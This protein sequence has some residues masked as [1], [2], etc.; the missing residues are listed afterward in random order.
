MVRVFNYLE[1]SLAVS[2]MLG[3]I[4]CNT[5]FDRSSKKLCRPMRPNNFEGH[6]HNQFQ[7]S[8]IRSLNTSSDRKSYRNIKVYTTELPSTQA[9]NKNRFGATLKMDSEYHPESDLFDNERTYTDVPQ[10]WLRSMAK[11]LVMHTTHQFP[12][13]APDGTK[14]TVK[15]ATRPSEV[16]ASPE[17]DYL[18]LRGGI[19]RAAE[20]EGPVSKATIAWSSQELKDVLA[21]FATTYAIEKHRAGGTRQEDESSSNVPNN[22]SG[23][24]E[25]EID[26]RLS[27]PK[28]KTLG[29]TQITTLDVENLSAEEWAE[30]SLEGKI[31]F[32]SILGEGSGGS[33]TKCILRGGGKVFA[34]KVRITNRTS[35]RKSNL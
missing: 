4:S 12:L 24:G 18:A 6:H 10:S 16:Y 27:L 13:T 28:I 34:L 29:L 26:D 14:P 3:S 2:L 7:A 1:E 33:V 8:K 11:P 35:V 23:A 19:S 21:S 32:L 17:R 31:Q 20:H 15:A 25:A 22:T 5:W 30:V 9:L